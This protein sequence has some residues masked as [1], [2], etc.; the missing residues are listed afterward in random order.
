M[1]ALHVSTRASPLFAFG[2]DS[3]ETGITVSGKRVPIFVAWEWNRV[4]G[5]EGSARGCAPSLELR[6][7]RRLLRCVSPMRVAVECGP[8]HTAAHRPVSQDHEVVFAQHRP[9]VENDWTEARS[10]RVYMASNATPRPVSKYGRST[11]GHDGFR[12]VVAPDRRAATRMTGRRRWC[13]SRRCGQRIQGATTIGPRRPSPRLHTNPPS[14]QHHHSDPVR[15]RPLRL[16]QA[17]D[18]GLATV[19]AVAE[20]SRGERGREVA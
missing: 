9:V 1:S 8:R 14:Q 13:V 6:C 16:R 10:A 11:S 20:D 18:R 4:S 3:D 7:S 15:I 17:D 12:T 2:I 5:D 19:V